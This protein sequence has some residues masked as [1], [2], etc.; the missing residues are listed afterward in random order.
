[1][2]VVVVV[3]TVVVVETVVVVDGVVVV[4]PAVVVDVE[5][6]V[7]VLQRCGLQRDD[8]GEATSI[9]VAKPALTNRTLA[10]SVCLRRSTCL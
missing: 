1:V 2:V 10:R 6:V 5:G 7:V 4:P 9:A 3:D 8:A